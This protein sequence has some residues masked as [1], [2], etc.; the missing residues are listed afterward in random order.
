MKKMMNLNPN[1]NGFCLCKCGGKTAL[2][3]HT[4]IKRFMIKGKHNRFIV[5]HGRISR[6]NCLICKKLFSVLKMAREKYCS[7]KCFFDSRPKRIISSS[8]YVYVQ[9]INHPRANNSGKYVFEHILVM[10]K[11]LGR[12]LSSN[13]LVHHKNEI[14]T[15]NRIENLMVMT[16]SEHM[17][18]HHNERRRK[19][20][21]ND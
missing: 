16:N 18:H 12:F 11:K 8:G 2:S 14:K 19:N 20:G 9:S 3:P 17:T 13:E 5:G 21:N 6:K 15:D 1:P 7:R 10:E 4:D